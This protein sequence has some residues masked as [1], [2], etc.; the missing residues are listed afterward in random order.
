LPITD[1]DIRRFS[2]LL[3]PMPLP[4]LID[5]IAITLAIDAVTPYADATIR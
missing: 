1:A 4:P 5:Y 2:P 3:R